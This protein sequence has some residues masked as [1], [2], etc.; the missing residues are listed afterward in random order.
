MNVF[1]NI[2]T[3]IISSAVI[4]GLFTFIVKKYIEKWIGTEF[5][6]RSKF[7]Q[8]SIDQQFKISEFVLE[9]QLGLYPEMLEVIYRLR[10][11]LRECIKHDKA[12]KW[13]PQLKVFGA[14]LTENL[15][16]Y[17]L[18]IS[19][20]IFNDLHRFKHIV[21]DAIVFH[22][23]Y[24]R[25]ERLFDKKGY[26]IGVEQ[27]SKSVDEADKLYNKITAEIRNKI[28]ETIKWDR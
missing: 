13:S 5:E 21:Q 3:S 10:N 9:R 4:L 16:K 19:E 6:K 7:N 12:Y 28:N 23:T 22:D 8:L 1:E 26:D 24:T 18:F 14:H 15:Y 25:E 2:A 17:R 11:I 20:N 27:L